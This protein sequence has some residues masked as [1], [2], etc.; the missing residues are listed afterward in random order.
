MDISI[1]HLITFTACFITLYFCMALELLFLIIFQHC[2]SVHQIQ[3]FSLHVFELCCSCLQFFLK[4]AFFAS[5]SG[6]LR[7]TD[8]ST[9]MNC[10]H[11]IEKGIFSWNTPYF[12]YLFL[13]WLS[14]PGFFSGPTF[15]ISLEMIYIL[16]H[17]GSF[18]TVGYIP[19]LQLIH[20]GL[21]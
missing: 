12:H 17:H 6:W 16:Y 9:T 2:S 7:W 15:D 21:D 5:V 11:I 3:I 8:L 13:R 20:N 18:T 19:V 1:H 4:V 10:L 14:V